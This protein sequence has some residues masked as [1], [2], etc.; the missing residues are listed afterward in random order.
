M[1]LYSGGLDTSV[2]L[3]WLIKEGYDVVAY[4][5]NLGQKEDFEAAKA[6]GTKVGAKKVIIDDARVDFV[7]N[8]VFPTIQ[9]NGLYENVYLMGTSIARPCI[10]KNA[11]KYVKSEGC[12]YLAHG[13]TGKVR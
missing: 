11:M 12:Q 4:C 8:F 13:A 5:A 9:A 6:K 7:E 1:L 3:R 2:I 10:V